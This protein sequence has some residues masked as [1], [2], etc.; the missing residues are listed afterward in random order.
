MKSEFVEI[1]LACGNSDYACVYTVRKNMRRRLP[2]LLELGANELKGQMAI[3]PLSEF[4]R[5]LV[6]DQ[7]TTPG[8]TKVTLTLVTD[9]FGNPVPGVKVTFVVPNTGPSGTFAGSAIVTT[10]AN[11]IAA[12]PSLT[13]N[14][15][16]GAFTVMASIANLATPAKFSLT[17]LAGAPFKIIAAAGTR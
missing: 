9:V 3:R 11:G 14:T 2:T 10:N 17:N 15:H 1:H 8:T 6:E 16:A 4:K 7:L 13:A 5:S 12:A